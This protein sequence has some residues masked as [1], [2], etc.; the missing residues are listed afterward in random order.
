MYHEAC[1]RVTG[2]VLE[3]HAG[4]FSY[5]V[6]LLTPNKGI[7]HYVRPQY[8]L[9]VRGHREAMGIR[10]GSFQS[11]FSCLTGH[12]QSRDAER[13]QLLLPP[14][15]ALEAGKSGVRKRKLLG[16]GGEAE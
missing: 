10:E 11:P 9:T 16:W 5:P 13:T 15:A 4:V 8:P 12:K 6:N 7:S 14:W 3:I 1:V 2:S